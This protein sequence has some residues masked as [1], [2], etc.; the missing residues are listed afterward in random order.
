M[1]DDAKKIIARE[2]EYE[3]DDHET[4]VRCAVMIRAL[5]DMMA[6]MGAT[7]PERITME[8]VYNGN[9]LAIRTSPD[10]LAINFDTMIEKF[11]EFDQEFK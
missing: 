2:H 9:T 8:V 11:M 3:F 6:V 5:I 10:G 1:K 7:L 4:C